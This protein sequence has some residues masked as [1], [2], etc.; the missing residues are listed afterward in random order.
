[1]HFF[2]PTLNNTCTWQIKVAGFATLTF[3]GV[4]T[5]AKQSETQYVRVHVRISLLKFCDDA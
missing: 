1:M 2:P 4:A 5:M 3:R